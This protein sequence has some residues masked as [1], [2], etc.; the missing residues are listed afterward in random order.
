[1]IEV[2]TAVVNTGFVSGATIIQLYLS[3]PMNSMPSGTPVKVLRG[4]EKVTLSPGA[5]QKIRFSLRRRDLSFWDTE[6]QQWRIPEGLFNISVGFS[7]RDL[8]ISV[9]AQIL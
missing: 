1:M 4:F 3:Y 2:D 6:A 9:S 7:S 8:P 5:H